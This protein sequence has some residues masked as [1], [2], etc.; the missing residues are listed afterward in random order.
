[1]VAADAPDL[2]SAALLAEQAAWLAPARSRLLRRVAVARRRRVLEVGAGG[3]AVT[4]ELVRRAGGPVVALDRRPAAL[5]PTGAERVGGDVRRL[6]FAAGSFDLVFCQLTLLWVQPPEEAV[7]EMVRVLAP[8]GALVVLEP[9][10]GGMVEYPPEVETRPLWVAG[11]RR[12][13]ADPYVARRLPALLAAQG[14]RVEVRLFAQ[15]S[16]PHPARFALLRGLPLTAAERARLAG[17]EAE[18]A[19]LTTPWAQ[20]AHLPFFLITAFKPRRPEPG[21]GA[22]TG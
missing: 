7:A 12:A 4:P 22:A 9:D 8:Q 5:P 19:R 16:P 3:G 20:V 6:P 14:L 10:Y 13:G 2:P 21:G 15:L 1:M 11:L 17:V 18:A